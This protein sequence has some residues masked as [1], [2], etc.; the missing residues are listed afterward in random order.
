MKP[1]SVVYNLAMRLTY[2][3]LLGGV[4]AC[5]PAL[6]GPPPPAPRRSCTRV[7][8]LVRM[9]EEGPGDRDEGT[10]APRGEGRDSSLGGRIFLVGNTGVWLELVEPGRNSA[11]TSSVMEDSWEKGDIIQF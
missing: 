6:V 8:L 11:S 2:L 10:G 1:E 9:A 7:D 3:V 4:G 5:L